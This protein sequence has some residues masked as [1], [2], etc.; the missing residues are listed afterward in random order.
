MGPGRAARPTCRLLKRAV[1]IL[2]HPSLYSW[3]MGFICIDPCRSASGLC[4][5][6][7]PRYAHPAYG[8]DTNDEAAAIGSD[9]ALGRFASWYSVTVTVRASLPDSSATVPP[10]L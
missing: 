10:A 4:N 3:E 5:F 9:N 8:F 7:R 1:C 2:R 6:W